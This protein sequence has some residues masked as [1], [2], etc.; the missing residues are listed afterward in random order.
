MSTRSSLSRDA[1]P[2]ANAH[3]N[4]EP[5]TPPTQCPVLRGALGALALLTGC[6]TADRRAAEPVPHIVTADIAAGIEK[7]IEEESRRTGGYFTLPYRGAALRMK[8]VRVHLEYLANL[9]PR[10]H[11]ACVDLA[12]TDGDVY[13]VDF[14]LE[15]DPGAMAVTETTVHKL[16]GQPLYLWAQAHDGT[17]ERTP[18]DAASSS[19]LG[20]VEGRDRF[21]FLYQ[22]TVPAL[23]EPARVWLPLPG[24]DPW[25]TVEVEAI[26][27]PGRREVLT[28]SRFGNRVL[29]LSLGPEDSGRPITLRFR[30]ERLEKHAHADPASR[31][32][33]YLAPERLVPDSGEFARIAAEVLAGKQGELVR[34]RALYDHTIDRMRYMKYGPG[35]GRGDA[36]NACD[37]RTGNCTDFH[38]YFIAL[39]RAGGIPARFAIGAAIPSERDDGGIDGYHCWAEFHA[40][41]KWWP[42]D[43]SEADKYTALSTYYFGRHP[44]NRLELSRGRDLALEPGPT[45][46]PI[47]FLAYPVL[48]TEGAT[49]TL[50]P[51]FSFRRLHDHPPDRP[52]AE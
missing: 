15:G 10:R 27:T 48:E 3:R 4:G 14:F 43:I 20:I 37:A 25:Q 6:Q 21:E 51:L 23:R 40:E 39:A 19:L 46:G 47:N 49:T 2:N 9:G 36:A 44:A 7:H 33:D 11:F 50:R 38:A 22:A 16:N 24:S 52:A 34:A 12:S 31:P 1:P 32:E 45:S 13:D 26:R 5:L 35:W 41:G 29:L 30:V 18:V 28:D 17:W 8:L 42:V